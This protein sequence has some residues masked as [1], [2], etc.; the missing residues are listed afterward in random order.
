M[1]ADLESTSGVAEFRLIDPPSLPT[2]PAAPNRVVLM[3]G[4]A[5]AALAVGFGVSFVASQLRPTILDGKGLREISGL[6]VLGA[7]SAIISPDRQRRE[8]RRSLAFYGGIG[9]YIG[10]MGVATV[11]AAIVRN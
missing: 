5:L 8:R 3:L 7:V 6:P 10:L 2:K 11:L 1:S 9:A 4:A